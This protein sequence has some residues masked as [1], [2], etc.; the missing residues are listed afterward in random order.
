MSF[1]V[2]MIS[3]INKVISMSK[4][5][6]IILIKKNWILKGGR[7][8]ERGSNPHSNGEDFSK[9]FSIFLENSSLKDK[10]IMGISAIKSLSIQ[11]VKI[12]YIRII[13]TKFFNWKLKV[14][15]YTI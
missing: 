11:I 9:F 4:I 7:V 8:R 13:K 2:I 6:N 10:R 5:R 12:V 1:E 15:S 14:I 3:G